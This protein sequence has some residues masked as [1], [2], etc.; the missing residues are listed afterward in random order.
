[1][2]HLRILAALFLV[3]LIAAFAIACGGDDDDTTDST[4]TTAARAA[5]TASPT[6]VPKPSG[7]ITVYSG[8]N[9]ALVKPLIEQFTKD[10]GITVNVKYG[11]T[12]ELAALL[13][14]EGSKSPADVYFAQD[15]G[16][17]GAVSALKLLDKLPEAAT[18]A[19]PATYKAADGTWVGVS[20]R[21]RVVVYN[22]DLVP[23]TD[24]PASYKDL[25]NA[26]W[27]GKVGWAP[28]NASFQA[29]ITGI[30]KLEGDAAAEAWLKAMQENGVKT[31]KSNGDIVTATAAG[32]ISAGLV[33]H[34]YLYGFLRDQGEGFKARNYYTT[35][36]DAGSLVN[37]AGVG[38]LKSSGNKPAANAFAQYLVGESA[39]KYFS[40]KT[41][42][43]PL[44]SGVAADTRLKPLADLKTPP[45][46]LSK[47]EDLAATLTLLRSSGA[48]Q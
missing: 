28:T 43:Y 15:A 3:P 14:E 21:A 23:A 41:Y 29:F 12:A 7:A 11:D 1:M 26:K 42:E 27:K 37:V 32:E 25:T 18:K 13:A 22:P 24:L 47:L 48:L 40:E 17:L 19:I 45:L 4:A 8:R 10:T 20:G 36:A 39:Q 44:V 35:A 30:R 6:S 38:V 31:Y 46:D 33:N 5:A 34:Y 16:G 9:E 2:K